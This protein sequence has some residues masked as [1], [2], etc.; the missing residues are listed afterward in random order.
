MTLQECTALLTPLA[1]ALRT[2]MDGP[3]FRAYH[4]ALKDV[5]VRLLQAAID[6]AEKRPRDAYQPTFPTAPTLS[7]GAHPTT[8]LA[9]STGAEVERPHRRRPGELDL[10]EISTVGRA[11][12]DQV[13]PP[14]SS[15]G[16]PF[17][18]RRCSRPTAAHEAP[19]LRRVPARA[20]ARAGCRPNLKLSDSGSRE[21][22]VTGM[23]SRAAPCSAGSCRPA[24]AR[25]RPRA[26]S[27][28]T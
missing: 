4:R 25:F 5:P 20:R 22:V 13:R 9:P 6:H 16:R 3:T 10:Q 28:E 2:P 27:R 23:A 18:L 15:S 8:F 11:G 21:P 7:G 26:T 1:L 12:A 19:P 17:A 14:A 24:C